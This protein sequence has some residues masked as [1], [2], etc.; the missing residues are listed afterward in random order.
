M[1][2]EALYED[3]ARAYEVGDYMKSHDLFAVLSLELP[4]QPAVWKGLASSLQMQ[5][6]YPEAVLNWS[7]AALLDEHDPLP[8]FHAAECLFAQ[9][10]NSDAQK[11]LKIALSLPCTEDVLEKIVRLKEKVDHATH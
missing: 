2:V 8:H 7:M 10:E 5:K 1:D 6:M 3:A 4:R 11:A 9:N